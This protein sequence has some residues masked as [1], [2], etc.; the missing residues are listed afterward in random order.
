MSKDSS[1]NLTEDA[2]EPLEDSRQTGEDSRQVSEDTR[3]IS[4]NS[5]ELT[6]KQLDILDFLWEG[7]KGTKEIADHLSVHES[8]ARKH[9]SILRDH[10][11]IRDV[12]RGYYRLSEA[13][14]PWTELE[15]EKIIDTF[16]KLCKK[17]LEQHLEKADI[18]LDVLRDLTLIVDRLM[19]RWNLT[20]R[21]YDTNTR[22]AVEDAKQKTSEREEQALKRL[23][24]EEQLEVVGDYDVKMREL[25]EA[26]PEPIQKKR[27]PV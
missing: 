24:P 22:Q 2:H 1:Q 8:T 13:L 14:A 17:S 20:H 4:E 21:G 23:P 9:I 18:S 19:K 7:E 11:K 5:A 25:L 26:L 6:G 12:K 10:G 15:N 3:Q 16:M 27:S